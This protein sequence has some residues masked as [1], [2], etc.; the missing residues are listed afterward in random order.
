MVLSITAAAGGHGNSTFCTLGWTGLTRSSWCR[1]MPPQRQQGCSTDSNTTLWLSPPETWDS[2]PGIWDRQDG[3]K[4]SMQ[5]GGFG[6]KMFH[7]SLQGVQHT[8]K[9]TGHGGKAKRGKV[10]G[11]QGNIHH[12]I[13]QDSLERF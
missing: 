4:L 8:D 6:P 1:F 10:H 13:A 11:V 3:E 2:K 7:Y 9:R 12:C 5:T